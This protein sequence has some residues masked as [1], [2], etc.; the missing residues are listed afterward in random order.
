MSALH[1]WI[2]WGLMGTVSSSRL[3]NKKRR[4]D[5]IQSWVAMVHSC[6]NV[7]DCMTV[8]GMNGK[9]AFLWRSRRTVKSWE[10]R[11]KKKFVCH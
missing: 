1:Y 4:L 8:A 7:C 11:G 2:M 3:A 10:I 9:T 5:V 6:N